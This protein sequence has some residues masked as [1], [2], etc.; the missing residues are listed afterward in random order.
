MFGDLQLALLSGMKTDSL[1]K[2]TEQHNSASRLVLRVKFLRY[3]SWGVGC[4]LLSCLASCLGVPEK[5]PSQN[6]T[7]PVT[8]DPEIGP[9]A[10]DRPASV[11][12]CEEK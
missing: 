3:P 5:H 4:T 9:K 12:F 1:V 2:I 10:L 6:I 8:G 7:N 11:S